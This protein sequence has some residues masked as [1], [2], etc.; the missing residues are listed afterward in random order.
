MNKLG[1]VCSD[2]RSGATRQSIGFLSV[3][4]DICKLCCLFGV[5]GA[6]FHANVDTLDIRQEVPM[7][8]SCGY[9]EYAVADRRQGVVV[10]HG[11]WQGDCG[12]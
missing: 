9:I 10:Q 11:I 7:E 5:C 6:V 1:Y 4:P 2:S 3:L 8:C 12:Y